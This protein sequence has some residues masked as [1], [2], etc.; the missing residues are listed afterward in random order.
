MEANSAASGPV[1][2]GRSGAGGRKE[3]RYHHGDLRNALIRAAIELAVEGG[4]DAV[5]LRAAARKVGVSATAAYRHF[6]GQNDLLGAVKEYGQQRLVASMESVGRDEVHGTGPAAT[7]ARMVAL[8]RG[9]IRFAR[10]EPGL[11]R[12]AFCHKVLG[13][14]DAIP[15]DGPEACEEDSGHEVRSFRMLSE[16][17][18]EAVA[19]GL[20][21]PGRRPGAELS[22]WATVHG[23]AMLFLDGPLGALPQQE[24]DQV[25]DRVL[26]D[27]VAGLTSP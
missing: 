6:E 19:V 5:V 16:T 12:T 3:G 4:P 18:D 22:A 24:A 17:L 14:L 9:Y 26:H 7:R 1:A 13:S 21:A 10:E 15:S 8:G 23:T 25:V 27:I 20:I 11:Y 2:G